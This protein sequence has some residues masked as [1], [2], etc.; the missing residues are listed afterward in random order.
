MKVLSSFFSGITAYLPQIII[1]MVV[2]AIIIMILVV[3]L[4][5]TS[6]KHAL[7]KKT[8]PTKAAE[9]LK[10]PRPAEDKMPP[11]WGIISE[12]LSMRGYF[13]VGDI[14]LSFLRALDL[15]RQRL[16]TVNFKYFMPWYLMIGPE[17][18]GK[19][20]LN[21]SIRTD[22]SLGGNPIS[23]LRTPIQASSGAF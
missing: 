12:M 5:S 6:F 16:D 17:K 15:L 14:S 13:R 18:S 22:L 3:V 10:P 21:E 19:N 7:K 20:H 2:I 23:A 11:R 4:T 9:T 8:P 1:G